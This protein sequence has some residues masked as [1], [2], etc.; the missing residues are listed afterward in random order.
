MPESLANLTPFL[1]VPIGVA[2]GTFAALFGVGGGVINVPLLVLAFGVPQKLAQGTS[3]M[4]IFSPMQLPAILEYYRNENV[5]V[6]VALWMMPGIFVGSYLGARLAN[7]LPQDKLRLA[8][9]FVLV[10]VAA[11]MIFSNVA[12]LTWAIGLALGVAAVVAAL[13]A[14]VSAV[15]PAKPPTVAPADVPA[16]S[17]DSS[18]APPARTTSAGGA[19]SDVID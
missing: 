9:G 15:A 5:N 17:P 19:V 2:V 18:D 6:R 8:F 14:G 4:M 3:L 16:V 1:L 13:L 7:Y 10:Y 12:P 11:Y